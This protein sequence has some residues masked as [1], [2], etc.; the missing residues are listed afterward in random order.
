MNIAAANR[1]SGLDALEIAD[2]SASDRHPPHSQPS[3]MSAPNIQPLPSIHSPVHA[4]T[5]GSTKGDPWLEEQKGFMAAFEAKKAIDKQLT[6][7]KK[8]ENARATKRSAKAGQAVMPTSSRAH[9]VEQV[10]NL[11]D[12][13]E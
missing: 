7:V 4:P 2:V 5:N 1:L 6:D 9:E 11:V 12:W 3:S 13:S 8:N 10:G